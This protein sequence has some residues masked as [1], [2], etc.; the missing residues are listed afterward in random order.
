MIIRFG[1][2]ALVI[3]V[4]LFALA[5]TLHYW[6]GWLY[7]IILLYTYACCCGLSLEI[8]SGTAGTTDEVQRERTRTTDHSPPGHCYIHSRF[9]AI[10]IDLR[11]H[12]LYQVPSSVVLV[13][14][15]GVFLGYCL[16]LWVFKANS[17]A[18]RTIEVVKDQKV[19]TAGPYSIIRHPMYLGVLVIYL[20]TPIAL[21]SWW[22]VPVFSLYIP[23]LVWRIF[24]EEKVLLRDLPGY[25]EYCQ[26]KRYRLV[27]LIW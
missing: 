24:N 9:L 27:P 26:K 5:G 6:Q 1:L 7:W 17:Y 8:R 3:P 12:G 4:I 19:I 22:A 11:Q 10:A 23:L 14:D 16:I 18:S 15:A 20:L 21:G 25:N 13:A 2:A